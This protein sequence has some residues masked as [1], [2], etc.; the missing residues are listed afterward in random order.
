MG[1]TSAPDM[2]QNTMD[3]LMGNLE[4]ARVCIDDILITSNGTFEDHMQKLNTVLARLETAGFR[5]N[6]RKCFFADDELEYLGYILTKEG[7]KPQP[8][9]VEATLWLQAPKNTKQ[10]RHFL[11]MVNYYR[12]MWHCRSHLLAAMIALLLKK[13]AWNWTQGCQPGHG[14]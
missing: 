10:L 4:C 2:F 11:G 13:R 7:V 12:D 9:K 8:K 3:D 5:A 1:I 14:E 6:V